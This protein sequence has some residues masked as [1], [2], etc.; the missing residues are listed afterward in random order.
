[1]AW[2]L[3]SESVKRQKSS[4]YLSRSSATPMATSSALMLV[5][6]SARP[7]AS[8][9]KDVAE[10]LWMIAAPSLPSPSMRE[11]SVYIHAS[12]SYV[13]RCPW[14]KPQWQG[15]GVLVGIPEEMGGRASPREEGGGLGILSVR[16]EC[17]WS[18]YR[19]G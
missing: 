18:H 13:M 5:W 10:G 19:E 4:R 7:E 14:N 8:I 3:D 6:V 2:R 1:M 9:C 15:W 16:G 11:P 17:P 12:G